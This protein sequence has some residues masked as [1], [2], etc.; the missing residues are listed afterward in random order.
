MFLRCRRGGDY[1]GPPSPSD[2]VHRTVDSKEEIDNCAKYS[3]RAHKATSTS[4]IIIAT[5]I[6][7]AISQNR[8]RHWS[9]TFPKN[10]AL[11]FGVGP[12]P[13]SL[14]KQFVTPERQARAS[15]TSRIDELVQVLPD[16]VQTLLKF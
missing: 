12:V 4:A 11:H 10:R 2:P 7:A 14:S 13:V 5:S 9:H 15:V 3:R 1:Q 6:S 8:E 16:V